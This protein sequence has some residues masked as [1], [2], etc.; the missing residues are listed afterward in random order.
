MTSAQ[1]RAELQKVMWST[2][3]Q[4]KAHQNWFYEEVRPLPVVRVPSN[5]NARVASDC[6]FY[7][8]LLF[9]AVDGP[10]PTGYKGEGYG[11][12][13]SV[14]EHCEHI[15]LSQALPGDAV[16]W[17]VGGSIHIAWLYR[18]HDNRCW[19]ANM[20]RQGEPEFVTLGAES[21]YHAGE[22]V[23]WLRT[24]R[25][26]AKHQPKGNPPTKPSAVTTAKEKK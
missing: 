5:G 17:G 25:P 26:D 23:T 15:D 20:G 7:G 4:Q 24:V 6:S 3:Q 1:L 18:W 19:L 22:P 8:K 21:A 13:S 14:W 9:Y 16:T 10:D 12:S 2:V 11:N